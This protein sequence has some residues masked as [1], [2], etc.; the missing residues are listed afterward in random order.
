VVDTGPTPLESAVGA[1]EEAWPMH[2]GGG[3]PWHVHDVLE[4]FNRLPRR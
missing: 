2:R 1:L 3:L 4:H